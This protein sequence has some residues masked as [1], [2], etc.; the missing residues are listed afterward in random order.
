MGDH[1]APKQWKLTPN[2][3]INSFDIWRQNLIYRMSLNV[4]FQ[5]FL[6]RGFAWRKKT[7]A[8]PTRG[9]TADVAPVPEGQ[10]KT[11]AQKN[12][13][14][15]LML[16]QIANWCPVIARQTIVNG[17]TSLNDIWQKIR[18]HYNI[19]KAGSQFLDLASIKL[20]PDERPEDLYQRF[21]A[22]FT[23]NLLEANGDITHH[24]E[25]L[26]AD[27]EVTPS[28][29]NTIVVL[30]LQ[31]IHPGLPQLI[32]QRYGTELRNK[33]LA[34]I[35]PEI[36]QALD[37]LVEELRSME[38]SKIF[39]AA[40][41]FH[42]NTSKPKSRS[43]RSCPLCKAAGRPHT[44][45]FLTK[46]KYLPPD[47]RRA[48]AKTRY[49]NDDEESEVEEYYEDDQG[50]I[51]ESTTSP[52]VLVTARRVD[53]V[54]SPYL[55][56][57]YKHHPVRLTIDCG[58]TTSMI[59]SSCANRLRL[60]IYPAS[61]LASQA[62]GNTP[63][64]VIGEVHTQ[65]SRGSSRYD[66]DALVVDKLDVDI[67]AGNNFLSKYDIVP[68][69]ATREIIIDNTEVVKYGRPPFRQPS[70]A[71]RTQAYL[72]RS[73]TRTV[74]LPGEYIT[75]DTPEDCDSDTTW[76][77]EPRVDSPLH[78]KTS[79]TWPSPQ[80]VESVDS[81]I[82]IVN[83]LN[84]PIMIRRGDQIGQILPVM[85]TPATTVLDEPNT[86]QKPS[87]PVPHSAQLKVDPD[88]ILPPDIKAEFEAL[89]SQYDD[90]FRPGV[91]KYNGASGNIEAHVNMGPVLPPQRKGRMPSYSQDKLLELQTKFDELEAEGVFAK[92]EQAHVAVEYLNLSFLIKKPSGGT[93]LVT[94]FAEVGQYS[95]PQPSL[96]PDVDSTLRSI[97]KWRYIVLSDLSQSFYQIPLSHES[98]K[99]CGVATPFKGIRVYTRCAMGMP[100]SE[101]CLEELMS[102]VL[103][104][105]VEQGVV[106][107]LADDL[108]CGGDTPEEA[109]TNWSR[110]LEALNQN[111]LRLSPRKTIICPKSATILGWH[112]S[113]GTLQASKHRIAALATAAPPPT[114]H[115]L[116]SFI[117]AYKV[118]SRVLPGYCDLLHPL[119]LAVAGRHSR[120]NITWTDDLTLA[121]KAAQSA[122]S[123]AK[124]ITLPRRADE[125]WLVTDASTKSRGIGATLY[126]R[127]QNDLVLAGFF[128]AKLKQHQVTWLPCEIEALSISCAVSHF[129]PYIIQSDHPVHILTDSKPCIDAYSKLARGEFSNSARVTTFLSTLS[130]FPVVMHHIPGEKN[131]ASDFASRHPVTCTNSDCQVC[132][133]VA[134]TGD[135]VIRNLTV[136]DV[137]DG[138]ATMPFTSR[139]AWRIT[140]QECPDL[141]RV[142]SHLTQGTRP[143]KKMT[144]IP[145]VK[146]YL[147]SVTVA[148]DGLLVVKLN[149]PFQPT[150][151]RIV[152]PQ[153]VV[154]GLL[155][156]IHI[157]FNHPSRHQ[158][159]HL[160]TK[161]FYAI[162]MDSAIN[163]VVDNCHHC[164]AL[165]KVKTH[166]QVQSTATPPSIVG[167]SYAADVMRR[168]KQ[169]ILVIRETVSSYTS[170]TIIPSEKQHDLRDGLLLLLSGLTYLGNTHI[171]I[172][173]D[174]APGFM[175]LVNDTLLL[176]R[177]IHL[178]IGHAKNPNKN[179]VAEHAV[180][181]MATE[182]LHIAPNGGPVSP[183]T[184]S[185]AT[186]NINTRIRRDGLSAREI[187]TQR[188]Q[189]TGEQLPLEDRELIQNQ[190][191]S[192]LQNH[193]PSA[194]SKAH[195]KTDTPT[196]Q[197]TVGDLV[198]LIHDRT[199]LQA[200]DKYIVMSISGQTC[201]I[202]KFTKQQLRGRLYEVPLCECY[203]I[204]SNVTASRPNQPIRGLEAESES[205]DDSIYC[206]PSHTQ[207]SDTHDASQEQSD[208]E[209]DTPQ[210]IQSPS[211][212]PDSEH[213]DLPPLNAPRRSGRIANR[214][215][216]PPVWQRDGTYIMKCSTMNVTK[217]TPH[218][219]IPPID[220][221]HDPSSDHHSA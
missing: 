94:S 159:K 108:Y 99:Y 31:Q 151:D 139:S 28:L 90:V 125:L 165:K 66:L 106:A 21:V 152:I 80:E 129:T 140:Q 86:H 22:F 199:K 153:N 95:K 49:I 157:K 145:D 26:E 137:T 45:H 62:D 156:A 67:L 77:L 35:K 38:E 213:E 88:N 176:Q 41:P 96:M 150:R 110:V 207:V 126:L 183:L 186:A 204:Q 64:T 44:S 15:E 179:P 123:Q 168:Y 138:T 221:E 18:L 200:R 144:K 161:Y 147:K 136:T 48:I 91:S 14:L 218:M 115:G 97:A 203:C 196:P 116:R 217:H 220:N 13:L 174:P 124:A 55:N 54:Q 52:D 23:D 8:H 27:E 85:S 155:T 172:R 5:P 92:P 29:E 117:G 189:V 11:A 69:L 190:H 142:H 74:L 158:M 209:P 32:K 114:V 104:D 59:T 132:R 70:V 20:Q 146:R 103:G 1:T 198:Y 17:S 175:A 118:L 37:S 113:N 78:Q 162:R 219:W 212:S 100:G 149:Q 75:V 215:N 47:D 6:E 112:W 79:V 2:E 210:P 154:D 73:P 205:D 211:A 160:I 170:C 109:L 83:S 188:D 34:S 43:A 191:L 173:V 178:E 202:R 143:T 87:T 61:Q 39:R 111:N 214:Q 3:T 7:A 185:L 57:F 25:A 42:Q 181:E 33:S 72:V 56:M 141:R 130:R 30:W 63:L 12:T 105:L 194:R 98:M 82:R 58:A 119:D 184:L 167:S 164:N 120:E 180:G 60:R 177:N 127:R 46:C 192:R 24:S 107:K 182:L 76:A 101:T 65:V 68:R 121:F 84:E 71:R 50:H 93:R 40:V 10:R 16:N 122:L 201:K 166:M 4:D 193:H 169:L 163:G 89:H 131:L 197:I 19:Q 36:S 148:H 187:W 53:I 216:K 206:V 171:T 51:Q 133:F 208:S 128:N 134:D 135:S 102:R 195:G 81:R 9:L